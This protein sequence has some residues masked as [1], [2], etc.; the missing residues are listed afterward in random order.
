M[1]R[2]LRQIS[3]ITSLVRFQVFTYMYPIIIAKKVI[4]TRD[5]TVSTKG[6]VSDRRRKIERAITPVGNPI[7][8]IKFESG[9]IMLTHVRSLCLQDIPICL[10]GVVNV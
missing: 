1:N 8:L 9:G 4:L 2:N 3:S 6:R 7:R 5:S 10:S